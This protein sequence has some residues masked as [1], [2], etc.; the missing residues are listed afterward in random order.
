MNVMRGFF[1]S[2]ARLSGRSCPPAGAGLLLGALLFS[3]AAP[4]TAQDRSVLSSEIAVSSEGASLHL[5]FEDDG[6]L[7]I[8]FRDG[9]VYIDGDDVGSYKRG[10]SLESSWRSL[11]GRAVALSDGPLAEALV[12]WAP[13]DDTSSGAGRRIH[14]ALDRALS[15]PA[16]VEAPDVDE[17]DD[18]QVTVSGDLDLALLSSLM[19]RSERFIALAEALEDLDLDFQDL[20]HSDRIQ[21]HVGETVTVAEDETLTAN[22]ILIDSDLHVRGHLAGNAILLGGSID[23]S[24]DARIDGEVQLSDAR[25]VNEGGTVEGGIHRLRLDREVMD[26]ERFDELRDQLRDEIRSEIQSSL[27]RSRDGGRDGGVLTPFRY[28]GRGI[29]GMM[30]NLFAF[31]FIAVLAFVAVRFFG[32]NLD[33]VADAARANPT[34]AGI[35]GVAGSFLLLPVWILGIVAL[36]ISLIGIPVLLAWIPLFPVAAV[37]AAALG[38]L[39]VARN[40]GD[41]VSRQHLQGFDWVRRSNTLSVLL[42]GVAA[43]ILPFFAANFIQ[44]A[45]PWLGFVR[46]ILTFVGSV[47]V[48]VAMAVG[49]G[50]V[51]LTRGGRRRDWAPVEDLDLDAAT[52]DEEFQASTATATAEPPAEDS[53]DGA[54]A[55]EAEAPPEEPEEKN[56][57]A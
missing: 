3:S 29:A 6:A 19:G 54:E 12:A 25:V 17:S 16:P 47:A 43:L 23:V 52:W 22:L 40:L 39:A 8:E 50:A 7:D 24:E 36:C 37:L 56:D 9:T 42:A 38:F 20:D 28:V 49:F 21:V 41:W 5:S 13:P 45:G 11:L 44:M 53:D 30:Q 27:P 32:A 15:A 57:D 14:Q 1:R 10:D 35:V 55:Q 18:A 2:S 51:L 4:L 33:V 34:R 31:A 46:G 26:R 48:S